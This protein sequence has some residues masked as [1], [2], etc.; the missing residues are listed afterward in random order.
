MAGI[1]ALM[2]F[3]VVVATAAVYQFSRGGDGNQAQQV[4]RRMSRPAQES[5][6]LAITRKTRRK[7]DNR[8]GALLSHFNLIQKLEEN[9]WQAGIYMR[10][11]EIVLIMALLFGAGT[12]AG[13]A[14]GGDVLVGLAAGLGL[15]VLP[16][17]YIRVRQARRLKAFSAQLPEVLDLL[18]SSLQAG[19]SLL[20]GFQVVVEEFPDPVSSE[21]R[22]VLEQTRLGVPLP[23][24]F[25]DML[26]RVPEESLRL[27]AVAVKV[28]AEVG[29]SLAEIINHLAETIRARQRVQLQI[30]AVTAQPRLS[31]LIVGLL[32][33]ILLMLFS[34]IQP[35][36]PAVLFHDPL[37]Q[38]ILKAAITLDIVA[39]VVIRRILRLNF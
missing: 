1:L 29:N 25:D 24:A 16:L 36:Y 26:K 8:L 33:V 38:M 2:V 15:S 10:V 31:G 19:H 32:P 23:R 39:F 7:D 21:V 4:A 3:S 11:S 6:D 28:Q 5:A 20:R 34:V 13:M 37:G 22:V 18:K 27:L 17:L 9:M 35:A 12:A 14:Y 30:K